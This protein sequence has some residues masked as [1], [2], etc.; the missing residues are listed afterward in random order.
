MMETPSDFFVDIVSADNFLV[1]SLEVHI[2]HLQGALPCWRRTC[3]LG[4]PFPQSF[5][6]RVAEQEGLDA[7]LKERVAKF[8]RY[9]NF[10]T[11]RTLMSLSFLEESI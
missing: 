8:K 4:S 10:C 7:R 6:N 5:F 11:Y 1:H 2:I 9:G 3:S